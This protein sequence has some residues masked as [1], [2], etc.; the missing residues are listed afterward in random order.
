V[1]NAANE[2]AVDAFLGG[3]LAFTKIAHVI[4]DTM[5]A[6]EPVHVAALETVREADEWARER[7]RRMVAG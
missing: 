1:L 7:A 5:D 6:H 3:R 4:A 2:I